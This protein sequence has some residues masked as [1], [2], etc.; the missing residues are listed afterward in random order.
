M[1]KKSEKMR[2]WYLSCIYEY[3]YIC[4]IYKRIIE[5]LHSLQM[6]KKHFTGGVSVFFSNSTQ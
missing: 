3:M 2:R 4:T 6:K 5:V 1:K